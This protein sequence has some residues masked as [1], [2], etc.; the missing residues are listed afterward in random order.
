MVCLN[1]LIKKILVYV[2][3]K[4]MMSDDGSQKD[5]MSLKIHYVENT[6]NI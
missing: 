1:I 2:H 5:L 4:M 6:S 3:T